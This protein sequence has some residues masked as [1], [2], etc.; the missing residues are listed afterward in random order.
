MS[1]PA[2]QN[3]PSPDSDP[4]KYALLD[5]LAADYADR[6]RK[7]ER[8]E[9]ENMPTGIPIWRRN[10]RIVPGNGRDRAAPTTDRSQSGVTIR[11][12]AA[13]VP[14]Q[15]GD[16]R[17]LREIGRG[18]MGIVYEAEQVSLGRHVALKV[19]L[20][21]LGHA[22][23]RSNGFAARHAPRRGCTTPTSSP[24]TT[25]GRIATSPIT[26][27]NSFRARGSTWSSRS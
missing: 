14:S 26:R 1:S 4:G 19:M 16:Y 12:E 7:G 18:G 2:P 8:P 9:L 15:V 22:P 17:V 21:G 27:C 23:A 3:E 25:W 24:F 6:L 5:Q 20:G 13:Q 10:P 11:T